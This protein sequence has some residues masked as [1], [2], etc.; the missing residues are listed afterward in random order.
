M[1][2]GFTGSRIGM[3]RR[4]IKVFRTLIA[5]LLMNFKTFHHGG[6]IGSDKQAHDILFELRNNKSL[7]LTFPF[8]EFIK[9][10]VH[11][12]NN[13]TF[14]ADLTLILDNRDEVLEEKPLLERDMDVVKSCDILFAAPRT[15]KEERRSDTWTTIK[16]ARKQNKMII[17]LDP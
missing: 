17:I 15:L 2:I 4:Q 7:N 1:N 8:N 5:N 10:I 14:R 12:A 16:Y 11:P 13:P 3:S 6:C 9:I